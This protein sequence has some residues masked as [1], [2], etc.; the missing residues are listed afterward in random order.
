MK[1]KFA[2]GTDAHE[3]V[4]IGAEDI[5]TVAVLQGWAGLASL[6]RFLWPAGVVGIAQSWPA[7]VGYCAISF[8]GN[9]L[10]GVEGA[11]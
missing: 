5:G 1:K 4:L 7:G 3:L 2:S 9:F 11:M 6:R 8:N 10:T